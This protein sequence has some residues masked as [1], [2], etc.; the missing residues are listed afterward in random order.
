MADG[1]PRPAFYVAV[2]LVI[3]GLVAA[4]DAKPRVVGSGVLQ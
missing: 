4:G 1:Q 2:F 3:I